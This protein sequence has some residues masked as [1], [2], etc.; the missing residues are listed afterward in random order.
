MPRSR[1]TTTSPKP[2]CLT[3][4][5]GARILVIGT[6]EACDVGIGCVAQPART[7]IDAIKTALI[8]INGFQPLIDRSF[9]PDNRIMS[10]VSGQK[11]LGE[12]QSERHSHRREIK[13]ANV[14]SQEAKA[15]EA[16][17]IKAMR[18]GGI[19]ASSDMNGV[20]PHRIGRRTT[21][22]E[23]QWQFVPLLTELGEV[24]GTFAA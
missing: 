3:A 12:Y 21:V 22:R 23:P 13:A 16:D 20:L 4:N 15:N 10:M 18:P 5:R 2:S 7:T 8:F 17:E 19:F 24:A 11:F 6:S 1:F 9:S 14:D